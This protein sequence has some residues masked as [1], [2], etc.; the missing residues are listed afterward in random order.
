MSHEIRT[1]IHAIIGNIELLRETRLDA[2]QKEYAGTVQASAEALLGL[3]NDI[4]DISRIEA[5][6]LQPEMIDFYLP[7]VI[8][9]AA[10][11]N[12]LEAHRKGLELATF[13]PAHTP[14]LI[15]GDPV[16]LR[17]VL[18]NLISNAVKFTHGGEV[19]ASVS[20][21]REDEK[22]ALLEFSVR[23]TGI[24][25]PHDRIPGLF[26]TFTQL[27]SSS[28]RKYGG[29]G[30]GLA[31]SR[32]LVHMMGG[33][34]GVESEEGRG[35]R[36]WFTLP[37]GKQKVSDQYTAVPADFFGG[38]RVLVVDDNTSAR[39]ILCEY[40]RSWGC[41]VEEAAGGAEALAALRLR[42]GRPDALRLALVDLRMQGMDGWQLA[43]E[44]NSD[45]SINAT[46]LVLLSPAGLSADE[47]K[48]KLLRWF[49]AYLGKPVR[50]ALLLETVFSV[51]SDNL[52]LEEVPVDEPA[53][54]AL[55][56]GAGGAFASGAARVLVADDNETSRELFRV[57]LEKSGYVVETV[58]DGRQ[59]V[60]RF[61]SGGFDIAFLDVNMPVM[62]GPEAAQAMRRAGVRAPIIAVT[63]SVR[64]EEQERCLAAGMSAFL[65][66]PFRRRD[67]AKVLREWLPA[68]SPPGG[69]DGPSPAGREARPDIID[70]PAA[71]D[72]FMGREEVVRG[73]LR[74]FLER[75]V[76]RIAPLRSALEKG[77]METIRF[78]AHA[79]KGGALNLRAGRLADAALALE[80]AAQDRR[81][82][83]VPGLLDSFEAAA[84]E[85]STHVTRSLVLAPGQLDDVIPEAGGHDV[86]Q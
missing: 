76:G 66:K 48:M 27:D 37:L 62:G 32:N 17:Q 43:S 44:I 57:V 85:L 58:E 33:E 68:G 15:R 31:I 18:V 54:D 65:A 19:V 49:N 13:L 86:T 83:E 11:L 59:A 56:A 1:P 72:A 74:G 35:S 75:L 47:A 30:L 26:Q 79:V 84:G 45:K 16:R 51:S 55:P 50:K 67:L 3:V 60:Q 36:F 21:R 2:E 61:V 70:F 81:S 41:L 42:A 73:L 80:S 24:G 5:G 4:L 63:A 25:I 69:E 77:D 78:E 40:L 10:D 20:V 53:D 9:T 29:S 46:R 38:L 39:A 8:E 28:T 64:R 82:A 7:A 14:T 12:A 22:E 52:D 6:K 23:D 34:I 71:V